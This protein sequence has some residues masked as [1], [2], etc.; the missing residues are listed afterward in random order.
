MTF[1]PSIILY[2]HGTV[3]NTVVEY[4]WTS[5]SI[6][7]PSASFLL[8]VVTLHSFSFG[9]YP[10]LSKSPSSIACL[11]S[12]GSVY[13]HGIIYFPPAYFPKLSVSQLQSTCPQNL[14]LIAVLHLSTLYE[15]VTFSTMERSSSSLS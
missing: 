8:M 1:R 11:Y 2:S 12:S 6:R 4:P 14:N 5:P 15:D 7:S 13:T 9:L 10:S 3:L